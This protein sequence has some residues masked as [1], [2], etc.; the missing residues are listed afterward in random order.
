MNSIKK[1][2]PAFFWVGVV[3]FFLHG[4][5]TFFPEPLWGMH[6]LAF[7]PAFWGFVIPGLAI[8]LFVPAV[9]KTVEPLF[10]APP[11]HLFSTPI[12]LAIAGLWGA[13]FYFFPIASDNYG[14]SFNYAPYLDQVVT[15][16]PLE[17]YDNLL[18]F[19]LR[20]ASGR[21]TLL[22][23]LTLCSYWTGAN[24]HDVFRWVGILCGMGFV[25]TW[26]AGIRDNVQNFQW[27]MILSIAGMSAPFLL[28]FFGHIDTYAIVYLALLIW[29]FVLLRQ[30]TKP[31][32]IRIWLLF[33]GLLV[34][35]KLHPLSVLLFPGW[36]LTLV[37]FYAPSHRLVQRLFTPRGI[38]IAV[39]SPLIVAGAVL[40]F[41]VFED[42]HDARLLQN[43]VDFDRLFLPLFSPE[44][45]LDRYNLLGVNHF[46]DFFNV[47]FLWS[48]VAWF[49]FASVLL[50][51]RKKRISISPEMIV[52]GTTLL[53][54]TLFLFMINPLIS[55][56]MDWDLFSIPAVLL[57]VL[58][59]SMVTKL[60]DH[61]LGKKMVPIS[62]AL[63]LLCLP[64][65]I[66]NASLQPLSYRLESVGKWIYRSYYEHSPRYIHTAIG[67]LNDDPDLYLERKQQLILDLEPFAL[68]GKDVKYAM[69]YTDNGIVYDKMKNDLPKA[70]QAFEMAD[71]YAPHYGINVL[72][73]TE[74]CFRMGDYTNA[75]K[76]A[77]R[78]IELGHPSR[79]QALNMAIHCALEAELYSEAT[80]H[81]EE[82]LLM[83]PD[84][85][86]IAEMLQRLKANK[87]LSELKNAF[88]S[89]QN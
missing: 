30:L 22:G 49:V 17:V 4:V 82:M 53:I 35:I 12:L 16:L 45:P 75:Y 70:R 86:F 2:I 21:K 67:M 26:L 74:V 51:L 38:L 15:V 23:I 66:V 64:V 32:T 18:N 81:C 88:R 28:I 78:L 54:F 79:A 10:E 31:S 29:L 48:P 87:N 1:S 60:Q 20:P 7:L 8:A 57:L 69:F 72:Q 71:T 56:P 68:P 42:H 34:C 24:Y 58:I 25:F 9:A 3:M 83:D 77:T 73:L 59:V 13:L 33:L 47:L 52:L 11:I 50:G 76:Y 41:F 37:H 61:E 39:M 19:D 44:A 6:Y 5:G 40:Y 65:F 80:V 55:M 46:V 43:V 62:L 63:A 36:L 84:N 27:R 89:A 85:Q 14:D